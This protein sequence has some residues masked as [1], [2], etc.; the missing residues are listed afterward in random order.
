MVFDSFI[1]SNCFRA[2]VDLLVEHGGDLELGNNTP[3]MEASHEGHLDT[4]KHIL[5]HGVRKV[6]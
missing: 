3:L 4:V 5:D 6:F 1:K 2:V